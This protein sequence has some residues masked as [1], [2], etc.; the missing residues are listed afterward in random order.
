MVERCKFIY[1]FIYLL[2]KR[3]GS[4]VDTGSVGL[5]ENRVFFTPYTHNHVQFFLYFRSEVES[6]VFNINR[7]NP[8]Y[9]Y[10]EDAAP[11]QHVVPKSTRNE[12]SGIYDPRDIVVRLHDS[13]RDLSRVPS[14]RRSA[15][16]S[17]S[18]LPAPSMTAS[19]S[20]VIHVRY[21]RKN[22]TEEPAQYRESTPAIYT[23]GHPLRDS[24]IPD[25]NDTNQVKIRD[26]NHDNGIHSFYKSG[27]SN[28]DAPGPLRSSSGPF[29]VSA[30]TDIERMITEE[31][32]ERIQDELRGSLIEGNPGPSAP[33]P[34]GVISPDID[35]RPT[36]VESTYSTYILPVPES[37]T[38]VKTTSRSTSSPSDSSHGV[39]REDGPKYAG[40]ARL[41]ILKTLEDFIRY[42]PPQNK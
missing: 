24:Y 11:P 30:E 25:M 26:S 36:P 19:G 5:V 17:F 23:N 7:I 13:T 40:S 31:A 10:G 18:G 3:P 20:H 38:L 33:I 42:H 41:G 35:V 37:E 12:W 32:R 39:K 4:G 1:L 28:F 29:I 34:S 16:A 21:E 22:T 15:A 27:V 6:E 9:D 2:I 14:V 8:V